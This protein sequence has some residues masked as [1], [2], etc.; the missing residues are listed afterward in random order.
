[1]KKRVFMTGLISIMLVIGMM[2]I[3]CDLNDE[4]GNNGGN[5]GNGGNSDNGDNS[6]TGNK[7]V[8]N[9][10]NAVGLVLTDEANISLSY[11]SRAATDDE[12]NSNLK[13]IDSAG[14]I[15]DVLSS[16]KALISNFMIAPNN[17]I[18][19]LFKNKINLKTSE[20]D[21]QNGTLLAEV[22]SAIGSITSIDS[23][24]NSISWN[25]DSSRFK[26]QPIQFDSMGAIYYSG[27]STGNRVLRKYFNGAST[28][29]INDNIDIDDFIV[30]LDG[31]IFISGGTSSSNIQ[32]IRKVTVSGGLENIVTSTSAQFMATFPDNNIYFGLWDDQHFGVFRYLQDAGS[33]ELKPWIS[34]THINGVT[35]DPYNNIEGTGLAGGGYWGALVKGII[36]TSDQKV[37]ALASASSDYK[38]MQYYP[39]LSTPTT[40]I[41]KVATTQ[42]VLSYIIL[43]GLDS[44]NKNKLVIYDT[45][46]DTE[47]N[48]LPNHDIEVYNINFVVSENKIM[49]DGLNFANNK[50]VLGEVSLLTKAV[51][52]IEIGTGANEKLLDFKT[53][54]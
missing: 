33:L 22:D 45:L 17:K 19:I 25:N 6:G 44:S 51:N 1:M 50:V 13:K 30:N 3:G 31:S 37:Y 9:L 20:P 38:L 36:K 52:L 15:S 47:E 5:S 35:Y 27:Y 26:N 21:Y 4:T 23:S 16:G 32:W 40:S 53:F 24:L 39:A 10:S 18:Y 41:S 14:N 2:F 7:V 8:F 29:I 46:S 43:S 49:F 34:G 11:N 42:N 12:S 48:L 28:D 54:Y